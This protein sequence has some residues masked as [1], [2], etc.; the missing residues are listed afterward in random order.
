MNSLINTGQSAGMGERFLYGL[1]NFFAVRA[2]LRGWIDPAMAEYVASGGV[3]LIGGAY[4]WWINRPNKLLNAAANNLPKNA[5]LVITT[6]PQASPVEKAE[7]HALA[8]S[9][10]E[11]V[12]AKTTS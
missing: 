6:K 10:S 7:A 3:M 1:L 12:T 4:A 11:K 5:E 9:S 8:A 2:A